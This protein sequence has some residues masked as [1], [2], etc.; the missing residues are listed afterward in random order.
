MRAIQKVHTLLNRKRNGELES[1][2]ELNYIFSSCFIFFLIEF[3]RK[4]KVGLSKKVDLGAA[5][6][7]LYAR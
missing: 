5:K 1:Q 3:G 7:I 4:L 6:S 2:V